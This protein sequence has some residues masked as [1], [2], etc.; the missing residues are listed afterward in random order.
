MTDIIKGGFLQGKK[1]YITA[2]TGIIAAVAGYL[3]GDLDLNQTLQAVWPLAT[4]AFL[5]K[6][7]S[8]SG[9]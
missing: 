4:M 6:G 3:V 9:K 2:V 5:R 1:T 8:D 7:V